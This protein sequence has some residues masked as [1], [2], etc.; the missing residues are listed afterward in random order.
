M[1]SGT[2]TAIV[3]IPRKVGVVAASRAGIAPAAR[4]TPTVVSM[5]DVASVCPGFCSTFTVAAEPRSLYATQRVSS[6]WLTVAAAT[7]IAADTPANTRPT[8]KTASA[9]LI[10][11]RTL[12]GSRGAARRAPRPRGSRPA[13][14]RPRA[15]ER[16]R[17][18]STRARRPSRLRHARSWCPAPPR[19]R[20]DWCAH[21]PE[22]GPVL[23][24]RGRRLRIML[25][26][27]LAHD[28]LEN[29]FAGDQSR[30]PAE[31]VDDDR[32]GGGRFLEG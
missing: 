32:D 19:G 23:A 26:A 14:A 2:P 5:L 12:L 13:S 18:P 28:F 11:F 31:L 27:D 8:S 15:A 30:G 4:S 29:V 24:N 6:C 3:K 22:P 20:R 7:P 10:A 9:T 17:G 1:N 21:H 25:V 16:V